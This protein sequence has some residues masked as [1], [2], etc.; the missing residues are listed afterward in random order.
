[1]EPKIL[2]MDIETLPLELWGWGLY[3]QNFGLKQIKHD[4]TILSFSAKWLNAPAREIVYYSTEGQRNIRDDKFILRQLVKLLNAADIVISKNGER[5]DFKKVNARCAI[6]HFPP[7]K[8]FKS[9]DIEKEGRRVFGFTSHSL[10]YTSNA[11]NRKYKK[12]DHKLYPGF[13]LWKAILEGD[14]RAWK[15]MRR[16]NIHDTLATEEQ[17]LMI[18]GWIRTQ[19]VG[20]ILADG[21]MRC[22]CGSDKLRRKGY[23]YTPAGKFQIYCCHV[24]G[25]WPR[26]AKNLLA[27]RERN[28][29]LRNTV[30]E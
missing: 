21:I 28:Y 6:H 17:Y 27:G 15:E 5:F 11:L 25:K 26:G 1:M 8:P 18:Q 7:I 30:R 22:P 20:P 13:E 16:Y 10:D 3:D 14:K 4:W 2:V 24:C 12:L 29:I 19:G 9:I 23:A